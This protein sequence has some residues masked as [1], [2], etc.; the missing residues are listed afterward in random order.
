MAATLKSALISAVLMAHAAAHAQA[1]PVGLWKTIDDDTQADKSL[2]RVSDQGGVLIG[3]IEKLLDPSVAPN[4]VCEKCTDERKGLPLVGLMVLR[5]AKLSTNDPQL[6]EGGD[7]VDPKN[8]KVYKARLKPIDG[9]QKLEM[10]GYL[11]PFY[12][13]QTWL[14]VE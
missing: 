10:R 11:G 12:R 1:T 4:A 13:T 8:G 14:R 7:I 2:I 6:W 9:G 3:R 5:N